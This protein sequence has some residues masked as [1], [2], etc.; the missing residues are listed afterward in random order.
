MN[1]SLSFNYPRLQRRDIAENATQ[2]R[3]IYFI[4]SWKYVSLMKFTF[5]IKYSHRD[6]CSQAAV[7]RKKIQK[8]DYWTC[9][10][11]CILALKLLLIN[12]VDPS[13]IRQKSSRIRQTGH[14]VRFMLPCDQT[15]SCLLPIHVYFS[16]KSK[17]SAN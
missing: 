15:S 16:I 13:K 7:I 8:P 3:G 14:G 4:Y 2:S 11:R 5:R 17:S 10:F 9:S 12:C 6:H 1:V